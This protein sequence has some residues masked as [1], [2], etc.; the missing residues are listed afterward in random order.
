MKSIDDESQTDLR[1]EKLRSILEVGCKFCL[2][3]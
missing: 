2:V 1:Q 3:V